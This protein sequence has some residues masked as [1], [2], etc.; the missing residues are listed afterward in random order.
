MVVSR[1]I[2]ELYL[3]VSRSLKQHYLKTEQTLIC[4]LLMLFILSIGFGSVYT[5]AFSFRFH[6]NC[7]VFFAFSPCNYTKTIKNVDRFH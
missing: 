6:R 5:N 1:Q 3:V 4:A 2:A 7:K